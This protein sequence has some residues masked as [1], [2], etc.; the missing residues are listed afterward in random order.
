MPQG[1]LVN[2]GGNGLL[3]AGDGIS[4][5]S[6][7]FTADGNLGTGQWTWTGWDGG[8]HTNETGS[9]QYYHATDG[10]TYFVPD[11]GTV[12]LLFSGSVQTAPGPAGDGLVEGTEGDDLI[13]ATYAE[14]ADGDEIDGGWGGGIDGLDDH[15]LAGDGDDTVEAGLGDDTVEG[16]GGSDWLEG[17]SGDDVIHGGSDGEAAGGHEYLD[18]SGQG[19]DGQDIAGGFTQSTGEMDVTVSFASTGNNKPTFEV[20]SGDTQYVGAGEP[21]DAHSSAYLFGKGGGDTSRV[22]MDFAA[23][24]GSQATDEVQNVVFRVNDVDWGSGN[25]RDI[26]EVNAWDADGNPVTVSL[27]AGTGDTVS[28]NTVTAGSQAQDTDDE[29]GSLLVEVAGPVSKITIDYANDMNGTQGVWVTDVHFDTI[30]EV[31]G[32][33]T[34]IGGEGAD[35]M[36]GGDGDD[37]VEVSQGDI[38]FGDG[39]DDTFVFR[40]LS[41]PGKADI[42]IRGGNDGQTKGDTLDLG[43]VADR[44]TLQITGGDDTVGYTGS[45][46]LQD[47]STVNFSEIEHIIC[48]TPGTMIL[49]PTGERPV[50]SLRP[51]DL[52]MTRDA[53]AQP[54]R[55]TGRRRVPA[56]GNLAPVRL[57]PAALQGARRALAVSPQHRF[58]LT[59]YRAEL[60]FGEPEVLIPAKHLIDGRHV[61]Q[62]AGGEVTYLHLMF[63]RHHVIYAEGA[64]TESFHLADM[65]LD[66]ITPR[67]REEIFALFPHLRADPAAYGPAARLCARRFEAELVAA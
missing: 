52:I 2:L 32:D 49:T 16:G 8:W 53:G 11:S 3:E 20:E 66:A 61:T 65:G 62:E 55:W 44:T 6:T 5:W 43:G 25:H 12:T 4:G 46:E 27:T 51:G 60:L 36:H 13:D 24:S 7:S 17:G 40:D 30:P 9:G 58:L 50:E 14:D 37:V 28:G 33:D 21:M 1:Y 19:G 39:G 41:E 67:Q 34:L 15:V 48:F 42:T 57:E 38:A 26:I 18:W 54:L 29:G 45:V 23:S 35:E 59:G 47:G 10:N 56:E 64:P 31:D 22:T 63:D